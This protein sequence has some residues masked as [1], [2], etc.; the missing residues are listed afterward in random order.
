MWPSRTR[1]REQ[2]ADAETFVEDLYSEAL[3]HWAPVA[4]AVM[5]PTLDT[6]VTAAA[7]PELPPDPQAILS[8]QSYWDLL[9]TA[10][11]LPGVATLWMEAAMAAAAA[12][13]L[14]IAV[15]VTAGMLQSSLDQFLISY[16]LLGGKVPSIVRDKAVS[17]LSNA[18]QT[19]SI[20]EQ[21]NLLRD[22]ITP[23]SSLLREMARN[24]GYH[25]A[26]ILNDAL[27][28]VAS[29]GHADRKYWLS[30]RDS[31]VRESHRIADGQIAPLSGSFSV[32]SAELAF[33][34]D[35]R[36]P[37]HE[38]ANCVVAETLISWP[39]QHVSHV[40]RRCHRGTFVHLVTADGHDL[41]VTANHPILTNA[42]YVAAR[43]LRPGDYV[44]A[45][46][47]VSPPQIDHVPT[48]ADEVYR[49]FRDAGVEK[50]VIA[51][52]MDFHH[53]ALEGDKVSV[54]WAN[55]DLA[56]KI[57]SSLLGRRDDALLMGLSCRLGNG[58]RSRSGV[59]GLLS[60]SRMAGLRHEGRRTASLVGGPS[61][62]TPTILADSG[63]SDPVGFTPGTDRQ[64]T[65]SKAS[66][67]GV[68]A[69][70]EG[71]RHLQHTRTFG[72]KSSQ[73]VTVDVYP[74]THDVFNFSCTEQWYSANGIAVHNCRCRLIAL[75]P[76]E[77]EPAPW[78][79]ESMAAAANRGG[80][81]MGY[82]ATM[83]SADASPGGGGLGYEEGVAPAD[84]SQGGCGMG[85][86][87]PMA[88]TDGLSVVQEETMTTGMPVEQETFR[89][90]SD[91]VIAFI[92]V[93]T[94]DNRMF[95]KDVAF[96][97]RTPPL[98]L[99]WMRHTGEGGHTNAF[100]VGVIE[101][102]RI[103]DG[104]VLASG[105]LLNT[106]EADEAVEQ[107]EHGITRPSVDLGRHQWQITDDQGVELSEEQW[108]NL[109]LNARVFTTFTEA[110]LIG[111]TLV[112]TPAFG[113]TRVTLNTE[114]ESRE[115]GLVAAAVAQVSPRVYPAKH[116]TDP[117]LSE[118]TL[119]TM[120][121]DGRIF[122]HIACWGQCHRSVQTECQVAPHS[123]DGYSHFHTSSVYLDDD[124]RMP[125][126]RL[127][128][129]TGHASETLGGVPAQAH[130]DNTGSCWA[131]V[132]VGEDAHG[133][134]FSGIA[135]PWASP[136]QVE[137]GL[138]SPLSGDW[139]DFGQGLE[140]V[141]AL[142]VNTPGFVAR[143]RN[144]DLGRPFSLVAALG[145]RRESN[146]F[147][148]AHSVIK[149]AVTEAL[150]EH[151]L[152]A[153]QAKALARADMLAPLPT[154]RERIGDILAKVGQ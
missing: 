4:S 58:S 12:K 151:G 91:A 149:L 142:S 89:T 88:P 124:T 112:A 13:T 67:Y 78:E 83:A 122:G 35:P 36:G 132:R 21:R 39:G 92:G 125:V 3:L 106:P 55:S 50:R 65:F 135:A 79:P 49:A 136:E 139:R 28:T 77:A 45:A 103:D 9:M 150:I 20:T 113:D 134:W 47:P 123:P 38:I 33:P 154:P 143:G 40:T 10:T 118:P 117:Q 30:R 80:T 110:E 69:Y 54:V 76:G 19:L 147:E 137:A 22:A 128:I 93:P 95:S 2:T 98:P 34:G 15:D 86:E 148:L 81:G 115:L 32:G 25:A 46:D 87:S 126:G 97:I 16:G 111:M 75:A 56:E 44:I 37:I 105:Y 82:A 59:D 62:G 141:A 94:S 144:D 72:M 18:P 53:D 29:Y 96:D 5:L 133:I 146:H 57:D 31:R 23:G 7:E 99:M 14:G 63:S 71:A 100:S 42:G 26:S 41:T 73:L 120:D 70:S 85:Y 119:P 153:A 17:L 108:W 90:F 114:R 127:T 107:L 60:L 116:F 61:E 131:L 64:T 51:R 8:T 109:P 104:K 84:D 140:L 27:M 101:S 68:S 130:Y 121:S 6:I 129:G 102:A 24:L 145:P 152:K 52:A 66:E 74:A 11:V 43:S 138:A 1:A 48:R